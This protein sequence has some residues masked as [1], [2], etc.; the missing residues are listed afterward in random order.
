[1]TI[2]LC[3]DS[4]PANP[5]SDDITCNTQVATSKL[6]SITQ[7]AAADS[8][9]GHLGWTRLRGLAEIDDGEVIGLAGYQ[10]I[11]ANDVVE[12]LAEIRCRELN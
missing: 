6:T 3:I 5:E 4:A 1:M 12:L 10:N 8:A 7:D 2:I 9:E 11:D